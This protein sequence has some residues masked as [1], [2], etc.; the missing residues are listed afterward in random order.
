MLVIKIKFNGQ[1][2]ACVFS[3]AIIFLQ[4]TFNFIKKK[5]FFFQSFIHPITRCALTYLNGHHKD[6]SENAFLNIKNFK[7]KNFI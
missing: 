3:N 4:L 5:N 1:L 2:Y 6:L 7:F